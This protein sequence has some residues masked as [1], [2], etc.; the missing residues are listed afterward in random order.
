MKS[1]IEYQVDA[2]AAAFKRVNCLAALTLLLIITLSFPGKLFAMPSVNG[3]CGMG[4]SFDGSN[5][6]VNVP[7]LVLSG[8]FTVEAWVKV[9]TWN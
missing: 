2:K 3:T 1:R 5:D 8:D 6:W 9:N 7:N 4:L